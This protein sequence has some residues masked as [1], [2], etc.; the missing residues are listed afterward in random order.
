MRL[1]LPQDTIFPRDA[2]KGW[3]RQDGSLGIV[4][5]GA[6]DGRTH[7]VFCL[8]FIISPFSFLVNIFI[9]SMTPKSIKKRILI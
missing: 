2:H 6:G 3:R 4:G 7:S 5:I 1:A 9:M 8:L